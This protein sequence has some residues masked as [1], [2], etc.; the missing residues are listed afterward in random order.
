[1]TPEHERL[2]E[3]IR[4]RR[5]DPEFMDRLRQRIEEDAYL[6]ARMEA[7]RCRYPQPNG[8]GFPVNQCLDC[9]GWIIAAP[10]VSP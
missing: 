4:K 5:D 3:S 2:M 6:L 7:H 9:G 10:D 1:M 8:A